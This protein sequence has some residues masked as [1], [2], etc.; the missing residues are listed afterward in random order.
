MATKNIMRFS[1]VQDRTLFLHGGR[2]FVRSFYD[3]QSI[4]KKMGFGVAWLID[5]HGR[6]T[7]KWSFKKDVLVEFVRFTAL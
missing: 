7:E 5:E 6:R 3:D 1:D 2:E 4:A